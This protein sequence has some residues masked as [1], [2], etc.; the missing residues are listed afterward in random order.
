LLVGPSSGYGEDN[1]CLVDAIAKSDGRFKG[2]AVVPNDAGLASSSRSSRIRSPTPGPLVDAF[3]LDNCMWASDWP[4]LRARERVDYGPLLTL[5]EQL[6]PDAADRRKLF[7]DTPS[8]L[9]GF[10]RPSDIAGQERG[11]TLSRP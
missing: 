6:F 11:T 5:V 10:D 8:R 2:I 7:W 1:R 3:T 4:F 9:F